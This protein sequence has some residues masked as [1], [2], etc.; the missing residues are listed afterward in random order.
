MISATPEA[1]Q[2]LQKMLEEHPGSH[3]RLGVRGRGCEGIIYTIA[4]DS[5]LRD[6]DTLLQ[7]GN[8]KAA[9]D[10]KSLLYLSGAIIEADGGRLRFH[11]PSAEKTCRSSCSSC[12]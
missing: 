3:I 12:L 4:I 10:F 1:C 7:L 8:C 5:S 2:I 11:N 9:V 6:S